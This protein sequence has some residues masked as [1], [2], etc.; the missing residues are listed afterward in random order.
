MKSDFT[1]AVKNMYNYVND[2]INSMNDSKLFAGFMIVTLNIASKFVTIKLSKTMES[3]LKYTFSKQI[4]V[5]VISWMGCRNIYIALFVTIIAILFMDFLLN[6][7]SRFCCL[8]ETFTNYYTEKLV[9]DPASALNLTAGTDK[10]TDE[11]IKQA[12][13]ILEK[14][15]ANNTQLQSQKFTPISY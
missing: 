3:Y 1:K 10:V 9:N 11:Q 6:E 7:E 13:A 8:P 4:L 14:A 15:K 12:E 5:F 2:N